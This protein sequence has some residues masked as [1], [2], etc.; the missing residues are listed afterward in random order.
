[1]GNRLQLHNELIDVLG[2]AEEIESRVY[3]QPPASVRMK[4]PCIRYSRTGVDQTHANN[5]SYIATNQYEVVV[6]DLDPDSD[7]PDKVLARFP[8]CRLDRTYTAD[9]L[10]HTVFTLYY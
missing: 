2:T 6:I 7:I 3:F 1:M 5:K 10:N 9:N 4:Y 8:R